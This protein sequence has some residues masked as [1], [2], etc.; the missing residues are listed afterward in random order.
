VSEAHQVPAAVAQALGVREQPG[1]ALA[2]TLAA[3]LKHSHLLLVLDNF[4]HVLGAAAFVAELLA[5]CPALKLLVTS[6]AALGIRAE[7][8]FVL[9]PLRLPA[10]ES[11]LVEIA[12]APAVE[13]FVE[14][15]RA[16]RSGFRLTAE[17]ADPVAALC[18]RLDGLPLAIELIA[19]RARTLAPVDLLRQLEHGLEALADGWR[20]LPE[21][22]RTLRNAIAWSYDRLNTEGRRVFAHLGV[23]VGG[24]TPDAA[25]AVMGDGLSA[26]PVLDTLCESSLVQAQTVAGEAR[27]SLLETLREFAL[28]QLALLGMAEAAQERHAAYFLALAERAERELIGPDQKAWFDRLA[29]EHANLRVALAWSQSHALAMSLRLAAALELYWEVRGHLEEG[30]RWLRD[31]LKLGQQATRATR[32]RA[33]L[34]AGR[35]AWRQGDLKQAQALLSE[36]CQQMKAVEDASGL[37]RALYNLGYAVLRQGD[38]ATARTYFEESLDIARSIQDNYAAA[39]ALGGLAQAVAWQGKQFLDRHYTEQAL[40][41]CQARR[42]PRNIAGQLMNL[43]L[44]AFNEQDLATARQQI[45]ASLAVG[46][47]LEDR[48]LITVCLFNLA[49]VLLNQGDAVTARAYLEEALAIHRAQHDWTRAGATLGTLGHA[50]AMLGDLKGARARQL[51]GLRLRAEI[52][53][54]SGLAMSLFNLAHLEQRENKPARAARLLGAFEAVREALG[55]AVKGSSQAEYEQLLSDVR[56]ALGEAGFAQALAAGRAL[57]LD[58]GVALALS[59]DA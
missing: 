15:A 45:E 48:Y 30:R 50:L 47:E 42:D 51:E 22:Q 25:Q 49:N 36:T 16:V 44:I 31:G 8:Q 34:A 53:D 10:A 55:W 57:S 58:E 7:Q 46:R 37:A 4:E 2:T 17:H 26:R 13:L 19:A 18:V 20:D 27:F 43:G 56:A 38:H 1:K 5:A 59:P 32:A 6:R 40:A 14:R 33:L 28:D 29:R 35:L 11:T 21:R 23:F 41:L 12:G 54:R 52:G 39:G 9:A 24:C 3:A